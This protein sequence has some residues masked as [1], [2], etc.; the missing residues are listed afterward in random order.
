MWK[1]SRYIKVASISSFFTVHTMRDLSPLLHLLS[2]PE[3]VKIFEHLSSS[4]KKTSQM[5]GKTIFMAFLLI[6]KS[7]FTNEDEFIDFKIIIKS[8]SHLDFYI[9]NLETMYGLVEIILIH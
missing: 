9:F 1:H 7:T 4:L 6:L 3:T 2:P 8:A 5:I